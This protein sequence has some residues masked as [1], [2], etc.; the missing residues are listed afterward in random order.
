MHFVGCKNALYVYKNVKKKR[1][2][3]ASTYI[4]IRDDKRK[5]KKNEKIGAL[6][7]F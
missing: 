6:N 2:A 1:R 3:F 5:E 4:Y 7:F